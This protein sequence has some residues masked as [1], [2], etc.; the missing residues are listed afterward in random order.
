MGKT[1]QKKKILSDESLQIL[2]IN[3]FL[4]KGGKK[5]EIIRNLDK[6]FEIIQVTQK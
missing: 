3:T 4:G 1:L 2:S 5:K 6:H